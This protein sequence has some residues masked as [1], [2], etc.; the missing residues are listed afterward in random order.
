MTL[1]TTLYLFVFFRFC[2]SQFYSELN[3]EELSCPLCQ[4]T[5]SNSTSVKMHFDNYQHVERYKQ[6]KEELQIFYKGPF[7]DIQQL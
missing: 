3:L 6:A 1:F 5:F 7:S 2:F 4:L